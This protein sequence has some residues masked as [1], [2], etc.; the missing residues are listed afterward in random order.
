MDTQK[1]SAMVSAKPR[2]VWLVG[3][4]GL[5]IL[6]ASL[7]YPLYLSA[8]EEEGTYH[9]TFSPADL[10]LDGDLDVLVHNMRKYSEDGAFSGAAVWINPGSMQDVKLKQFAA[11]PNAIEG[12]RASTTADLDD[13]GD[14]DVLIY[15]GYLLFQGINQGGAQGKQAGEFTRGEIIPPPGKSYSSIFASLLAGD[16][17]HDGGIDVLVLGCCGWDYQTEKGVF[18]QNISWAWFNGLAESGRMEGKTTGIEPLAGLPVAEAALEDLDGDGDLD[19]FAV[20]LN[21][22]KDR[23]PGQADRVLLNDGA[24]RFSD[25]GQ[26]L[27]AG[28]DSTSVALG[29]LDGDGDP[30]ALVGHSGGAAVWINQG[31]AQ[32]GQAGRFA[33]SGDDV[34]GSQTRSVH[35]TDLDSDGDLDAMVAG[36]WHADLWWNDGQGKFSRAAQSIPCS[37]REDVTVGDFNGDGRMDIFVA[38]YD[39]DAQVWFN[40]GAGIFKAG[41]Q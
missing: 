5:V 41:S 25:S 15:D 27:E 10:N 13:D 3:L 39:K 37:D 21:L 7:A 30:D 1:N 22:P 6:C 19:L 28:K 2:L 11:R 31:G 23:G 14:P 4:V 36:A 24:G 26:R 29:D 18:S 16:I 9:L 33:V 17:N 34:A 32:G 38:R 8:A 35:L 40:N 12:G 20:G